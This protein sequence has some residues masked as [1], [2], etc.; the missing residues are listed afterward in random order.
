MSVTVTVAVP[1]FVGSTVL[2]AFTVR[3]DDVSPELTDNT[4]PELM[5]EAVPPVIVHVT[6]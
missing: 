1:D 6:V 4:P 5:L 2:V 3:L